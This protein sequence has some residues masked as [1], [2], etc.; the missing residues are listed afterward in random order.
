MATLYVDSSIGDNSRTYAQAQNAS[1]PW[2]T[3]ARAAWGDGY[4]GS[5]YGSPNTADTAQ[6]GDT[7]L[8]AAGTYT[9]NGTSTV[10]SNTRFAVALNPANNGTSVSPI[11][12][13]GV[14]TVNVRMANTMRG[15]T[16]GANGKN[17]IVWDNITID[18]TYCGSHE[19]T[20]PVFF[21][22]TNTGCQLI[23]S[24]IAGHNG[25][26]NWGYPTYTNNYNAI[27]L[28][29]ADACTIRNNKIHRMW[30]TGTSLAGANTNDAGIM[31]Y[32]STNCVVEHNEFYDC[33]IAI[34]LKGISPLTTEGDQHD[35]I[36]RYNYVHDCLRG[37]RNMLAQD[38]LIYQ[39]IVTNCT[40]LPISFGYDGSSITT[41]TT[42]ARIVNNTIYGTT[43]SF[44]GAVHPE[45]T[46][47]RAPWFKNNIVH[48][49]THAYYNFAT[50]DPSAQT[51]SPQLMEIDRNLYYNV[52]GT[53]ALY[54]QDFGG[55]SISF[56]TWQGTYGLDTNGSNGT[57]P[58][59]VSGTPTTAS[60]FKLASN[61]QSALTLGRVVSNIGGT[62]G[63]TIPV[64]AY[65]TGSETIGVIS[66]ATTGSP[67]LFI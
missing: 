5:T 61:G 47:M 7:V 16:I 34:E 9:E 13:R 6:A 54:N 3:I 66:G 38:S 39:N 58:Q 45:G 59:F 28:E 10:D 35:N 4:A 65:I 40:D 1:T 50:S 36:I 32:S 15:P 46:F 44:N 52:S 49:T 19:D 62:T 56:A 18:D 60:D 63:D 29:H 33:G 26:Y 53:F 42:R 20:G 57:D 67:I 48:T 55:T 31:T 37:I 12:F 64:G 23:N 30:G 2:L 8:I 41:A 25:S 43:G 11:T 51:G 27:R 21:G 24:D 17:Y 14:G 22:G